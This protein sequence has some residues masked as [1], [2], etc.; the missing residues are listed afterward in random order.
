MTDCGEPGQRTVDNVARRS[1]AS[2]CD[3]AD[4]AGIAFA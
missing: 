1:A 4:T 3:E 2:V